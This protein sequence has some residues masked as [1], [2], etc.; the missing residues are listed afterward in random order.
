MLFEP[1][2]VEFGFGDVFLGIV[3]RFLCWILDFALI[4][5]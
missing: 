3:L 1:E 4:R 5:V 2:F